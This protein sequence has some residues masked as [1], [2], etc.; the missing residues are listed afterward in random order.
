M[1]NKPKNIMG[2]TGETNSPSIAQKIKTTKT[3]YLYAFVCDSVDVSDIKT[4][5]SFKIMWTPRNR[6][7]LK[8]T[9]K[10]QRNFIR[11]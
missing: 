5:P 3:I 6:D 11:S 8:L 1:R 7:T 10:T 2:N 9:A 4:K